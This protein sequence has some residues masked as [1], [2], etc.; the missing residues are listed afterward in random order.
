MKFRLFV[1]FSFFI[2]GEVFGQIGFEEHVVIDDTYANDSPV[3]VYSADIDNDG[4]MDI[5][6]VSTS[7]NKVAWHENLDGQGNFSEWQIITSTMNSANSVLAIDIDQDGDLD[8]LASGYQEI[9]WY[10]NVDGQGSFGAKKIIPSNGK[11][12]NSIFATDIDIDGDIDIVFGNND[13]I[14]WSENIDGLG[15][16]SFYN[17]LDS[18]NSIRSVYSE[19]LDEDGDMDIL[20]AVGNKITWYENEGL[21]NFGNQQVITT[22]VSSARSVFAIDID[23]DGDMD[24][25]SASYFDDKIAWYENDG[26]ANF[27]NQKIIATSADGAQSVYAEDLDG[28]GDIDVLSASYFDNKIAWYENTDGLGNFGVEQIVN[29]NA[30]LANSVIAADLDSDGDL[31]ILNGGS[32]DIIWYPNTNSL[33]DFGLPNI[34]SLIYPRFL[35]SIFSADIDGD[36]DMDILSASWDD[37]VAWYENLD[38]QGTFGDIQIITT[39]AEKAASVYAIDLDADGDL[40]V[41]SS[42]EGDNKVAWYQNDGQGNFGAQNVISTSLSDP[43]SVF[44]ADIDGDS[45]NDVLSSS[46]DNDEVAWFENLDGQGNF[47]EKQNVA[48]NLSQTRSVTANDLDGDNDIDILASGLNS[49]VWYRNMDGQGM[50]EEVQVI[51]ISASCNSV[52]SIDIDGDGDIDILAALRGIGEIVWYENLDG[53]GNFGLKQI[54]STVAA[55]ARSVYSEDVDGDGDMDVISASYTDDKIAWYSNIDGQGNFGGQQIISNS[56]NARSVYA[57]DIDSDGDIDVIS[58]SKGIDRVSWHENIGI[59]SNE[60]NGEIQFDTNANN[61]DVSDPLIPCIMIETSNGIESQ[62]TISLPNGF[63][64]LFPNEGDFTTSI[65]LPNYYTA[66]SISE[67]SSFMGIGNVDNIDFCLEVDQIVDDL[68]ITLLPTSQARPGFDATYQLV[69]QNVGTTQLN[70]TLTLE[71]NDAK[72]NFLT[73]SEP[74]VSQNNNTLT[75]DFENLNPFETRTIDLTFNVLPP[76]TVNIDDLLNFTATINPIAGDFTEDDNIF[77]FNQTVIGSYDPNDIRVLEGEEV[78]IENA[79]QYLH[80]IIRFQNTGTASA[81][82]VR[83]E[84]ILDEKLDWNTIQLESYSHPN[85]VEIKDGNEVSFIFDGIYLPDSTTNEPASHGFIAY[86]IKPK[87]DIA[88]GDIIS[89]TADIFFDFNEA[90]VTNTVMTEIVDPTSIK[91]NTQL[92]FSIFPIPTSG[93]LMVQSEST[94]A[95]IEIYDQLGQ[96][97]LTKSNTSQIDLSTLNRGFYFCK[98]RDEKGDFGIKKVVKE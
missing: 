3:A 25:L 31:D 16:Y 70:G 67:T 75:F 65:I 77:T 10:E 5:L 41:L 9:A 2:W 33:G 46:Y 78:L 82:N 54:I 35:W 26:L 58:G 39:I 89:S 95:E 96:L 47:G 13:V 40:D 76:P 53:L 50:F 73:A 51:S 87:S 14:A 97:V 74:I 12:A 62:T 20:L 59:N 80:Y 29:T 61:C 56:E 85:R 37:K 71:F 15:N 8:V 64:Q 6:S 83:V 34:V 98:V 69:Y 93:I 18:I 72:L 32:A 79:D 21:A 4:D 17:T 30:L 86:K 1:L 28:D 43:W 7:Q 91:E 27:G 81:I 45:D 94:I 48:T 11:G 44:A 36:A 42:S 19:D 52:Y 84:N 63:Y 38:G 55:G 66:S 60:I 24:V 92:Q 68:N 90:V 88:I 57:T 22:E 49:I 23:G